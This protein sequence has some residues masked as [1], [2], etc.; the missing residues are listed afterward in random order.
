MLF[1]DGPG[2]SLAV[3]RSEHIFGDNALNV[4]SVAGNEAVLCHV[5]RA[6]NPVRRPGA[7]GTVA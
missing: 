3:V 6:A 4:S 2:G 5:G 1:L 7:L